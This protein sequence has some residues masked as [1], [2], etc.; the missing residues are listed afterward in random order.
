MMDS[1]LCVLRLSKIYQTEPVENTDQ[2]FFLNMIAELGGDNLPSAESLLARLLRIEYSLG[3][4]REIPKGPRTIDL[5]LLI[6]K[7]EK[8]NNDY[9]T[10]PH[11]RMHERRFVLAPLAELCPKLVHPV[12]KATI[13]ELL[14]RVDDGS[15]VELW[16]PR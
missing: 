10:L 9:L 15:K 3:R 5:D 4:T 13:E 6:Y 14:K 16:R 7:N 2:P 8:R 1:G 12:L 11:P